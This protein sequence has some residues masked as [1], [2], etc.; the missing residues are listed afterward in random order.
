MT[1]CVAT[2]TTDGLVMLSDTRTNAGI[3]HISSFQKLKV[4]T[5]ED[6]RTVALMSAG[7]LAVTQAIIGQLDKRIDDPN[8]DPKETLLGA[9][10]MFDVARLV[11]EAIRDVRQLDGPSLDAVGLGFQVSFLLAG[12]I[13]GRA[14]R[15]FQI[16]SEGNFVE[17]TMDTPFLQIGE[18]RHGRPVMDLLTH[19]N[20][21]LNEAIKVCL[22]SMESS[23]QS[24]MSVGLPLDLLVYHRDMPGDYLQ[25]RINDFD[26]DYINIRS[27]WSGAMKQAVE[28]MA[29]LD[30]D[31]SRPV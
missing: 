23:L 6:E 18:T 14:L 19:F 13:K 29:D 10:T 5:M 4:W 28:T 11:G 16:Y 20:L 31:L 1:Y 22:I 2:L 3:D 17:A 8:G 26:K 7:N 24:N 15:L 27:S 30:I 9:P 12:Q 21:P 25:R